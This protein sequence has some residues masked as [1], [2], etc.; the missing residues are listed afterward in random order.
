MANVI[1]A[2]AYAF[3]AVCRDL[4]CFTRADAPRRISVYSLEAD[5]T[6]R[7]A[8]ASVPSA[9]LPAAGPFPPG[10][11]RSSSGAVGQER[12]QDGW[13]FARWLMIIFSNSKRAKSWRR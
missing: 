6:P 9:W 8:P 1:D 12:A 7:L 13:R 5:D 10:T 11:G 3:A 4:D 2:L